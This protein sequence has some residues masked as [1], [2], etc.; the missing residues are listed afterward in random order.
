MTPGKLLREAR[1]RHGVSQAQLAVR[2]GT[3]QSAIS[4]IE[5]GKASPTVETLRV[6]LDLLGEDLVLGTQERD[7]GID[8]SLI[9]ERFALSPAERVDYGL[10]FADQVIGISPN[11]RDERAS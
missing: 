9:R 8:R 10:A 5:S 7:W 3:K 1:R 11:V 2:A 6:L 4:R